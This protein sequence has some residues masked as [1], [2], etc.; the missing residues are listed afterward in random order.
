MHHTNQYVSQRHKN[1]VLTSKPSLYDNAITVTKLKKD[2]LVITCF[3]RKGYDAGGYYVGQQSWDLP[4]TVAN[5][6]GISVISCEQ[7]VSLGNTINK[8][9]PMLRGR[10][11]PY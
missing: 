10:E 11:S 1:K 9:G 6:G 8:G 2:A 3:S 5:G 4:A 7:H